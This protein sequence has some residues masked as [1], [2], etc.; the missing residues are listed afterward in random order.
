[1]PRPRTIRYPESRHNRDHYP[2]LTGLPDAPVAVYFDGA[3]V[4]CCDSPS[5]AFA[6]LLR[7]QGHSV[8]YALTYGGYHCERAPGPIYPPRA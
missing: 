4:A 8:S 1:M 2:S 5:V 7:I 3:P 6:L